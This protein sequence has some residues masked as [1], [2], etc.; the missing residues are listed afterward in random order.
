[1]NQIQ[2]RCYESFGVYG[3]HNGLV[4]GERVFKGHACCSEFG[5]AGRAA[6]GAYP[7]ASASFGIMSVKACCHSRAAFEPSV[8]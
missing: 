5:P 1:M 2:R 8:A 4:V 6:A 3:D 7:A